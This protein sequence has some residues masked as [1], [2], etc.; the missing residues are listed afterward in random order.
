MDA[1]HYTGLRSE[2]QVGGQLTCILTADCGSGM[3]ASVCVMG[4][5]AWREAVEGPVVPSRGEAEATKW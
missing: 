2:M 5:G 3:L 1:C 4:G